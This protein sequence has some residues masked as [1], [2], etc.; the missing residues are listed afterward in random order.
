VLTGDLRNPGFQV[1]TS[2]IES[3]GVE[4]EF[5]TTRLYG[6]NISA[7]FTHL[8]PRLTATNTVGALGKH[9]AGIAANQA[10]LWTTYR[11]AAG[12]LDG[13]TLGGGV[14]YVGESWGDT[15]N[16][17]TVPS[18]TLFDLSLRYQLGAVT[19]T[20][21]N[22]DVALNV[23]NVADKLY[24]G[25]CEDALNCYYGQGRTFDATIRARW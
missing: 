4:F 2:S 7:A 17:I 24:V 6:F 23:K 9:P 21:K 12:V 18:F 3:K 22:W 20:L 14:R 5:K 19:P 8:D 16:T 15:L 13:L 1:Q 25:S 11:F 10:S